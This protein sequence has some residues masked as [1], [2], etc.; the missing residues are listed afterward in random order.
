VTQGK[1]ITLENRGDFSQN[2][3]QQQQQGGRELCEQ[4]SILDEER[5]VE[6]EPRFWPLNQ[7]IIQRALN[8]K[9]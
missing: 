1:A 7:T 3:Q 6:V 8:R 9:L 2:K 5:Y 4:V